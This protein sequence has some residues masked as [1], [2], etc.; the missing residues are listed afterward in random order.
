MKVPS[1]LQGFEMFEDRVERRKV[2]VLRN[3]LHAGR[4]PVPVDKPRDEIENLFLPFCKF[5]DFTFSPLPILGGKKV[6]VNEKNPRKCENSKQSLSLRIFESGS[7]GY[8]FRPRSSLPEAGR[9]G[10][11]TSTV[12]SF[13]SLMTFRVIF[14]SPLLRTA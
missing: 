9:A 4:V 10:S 5:H 13:L 1:A 12:I 3:L 7:V 8:S 14:P 2:E 6:K 11:V